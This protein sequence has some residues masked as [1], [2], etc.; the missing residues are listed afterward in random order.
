MRNLRLTENPI[1][2]LDTTHPTTSP[3]SE[4][5]RTDAATASIAV[6]RRVVWPMAC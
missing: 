5:Y 3:M 6:A 4:A 1:L 2:K